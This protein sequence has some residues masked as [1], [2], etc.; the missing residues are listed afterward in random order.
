MCALQTLLILCS[1]LFRQIGCTYTNI[2]LSSGRIQGETL[3]AT[4][5]PYGSQSAHA[6]LGIPYARAP[7]GSLRFRKPRAPPT[8]QGIRA[9]KRYESACMSDPKRTY[10]NGE[11]GPISEDCLYLNVFTN[12][13]CMEEKRCAVMIV[14]HGGGLQYESAATFDP[15]ILINNFVGQDRNIVVVTINYR[16]G[17]FGFGQLHADEADKNIGL[18][19]ILQAIKWVRKEIGEFGGNKERITIAGHSGGAALVYLVSTSPLSKGL[20]HQQIIMSGQY[21]SLSKLANYKAT[22]AIAVKTACLPEDAGFGRLS[23]SVVEKVYSCLRGLPAQTLLDAQLDVVLNTTYYLG[24]TYVDG[25]FP[26]LP[27]YPD[28][29]MDRKSVYPINT[30]IGTLSA[31]MRKSSY[32]SDLAPENVHKSREDLLKNLCEHI[33][34]EL[35]REPEDF[36]Q[37]CVQSYSNASAAD[38]LSDDMEFYA[39]A[40]KIANAH[41]SPTTNVFLYSYTYT[42]AEK[43]FDKYQIPPVPSPQHSED[44]IYTFGTH[45]AVMAPKDYEIERIYSG[46]FANFV[47]FGDPSPSEQQKWQPYSE[48]NREYFHIDFDQNFTMPGTNVQ[49]YQRAVDFWNRPSLEKRYSERWAPSLDNFMITNLLAPIN[50]HLR[51]KRTDFDKS[52]EQNEQLFFER[53]QFLV[54]LKTERRRRG[55]SVR[56][57]EIRAE[58][59][60]SYLFFIFS[61]ILLFVVFH[62]TVTHFAMDKQRRKDGYEVLE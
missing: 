25:E 60:I 8:W 53:E 48:K 58:G 1:L 30:L 13:Y 16:L 52:F 10:K 28:R 42:G 55:V 38:F 18:F 7:V 57:Q 6:F 9:T 3:T 27:D 49:Y 45:R 56:D 23:K 17:V 44:L 43:A 40:V 26:M 39:G 20:I 11:G 59:E 50:S 34:Y 37:K 19:D 24:T 12:D 4:Y 31:E 15:L 33:G 62:V 51:Q 46:M 32:V 35:Y 54:Q 22:S 61:G 5:S 41:V 47:N 36:S 2:E 29:L 21:P 14:I